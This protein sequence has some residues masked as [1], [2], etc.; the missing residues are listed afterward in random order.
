[1]LTRIWPAGKKIKQ[2]MEDLERRAGDGSKPAASNKKS[3]KSS[4][5]KKSSHQRRPSSPPVTTAAS[6]QAPNPMFTPPMADDQPFFPSP[7][8][9]ASSPP[10]FAYQPAYSPP[11]DNGFYNPVTTWM[12]TAATTATAAPTLPPMTHFSEAYKQAAPGGNESMSSFPSYGDYSL[13]VAPTAS[14]YDSNPH[15]S[16]HHHHQSQQGATTHNSTLLPPVSTF[17]SYG[18]SSYSTSSSSSPSVTSMAPMGHLAAPDPYRPR[19][20]PLP[21]AR[22]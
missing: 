1:M 18:S 10:T 2:R 15:V 22:V 16:S 3:S 5:G 20:A 9:P 11:S 7:S 12:A 6:L 14:P 13:G 17:P 4:N 8:P 19:Y 21:P